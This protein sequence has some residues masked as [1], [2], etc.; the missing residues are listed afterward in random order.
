MDFKSF[1][2][3]VASLHQQEFVVQFFFYVFLGLALSAGVYL[4]VSRDL[5]YKKIIL[6]S[7]ISYKF[8][9][10]ITTEWSPK[11]VMIG[12]REISKAVC[13][14]T[15]AWIWFSSALFNLKIHG[16]W[17]TEKYAEMVK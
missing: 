14:R 6:V 2:I 5:V 9:A 12:T 11:D 7:K 3:Q 8:K 10:F 17:R 4:S 13:F 15:F 16:V 1:L